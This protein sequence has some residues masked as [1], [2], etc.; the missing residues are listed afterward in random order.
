LYAR[1]NGALRRAHGNIGGASL[2]AVDADIRDLA[3]TLDNALARSPAPRP[4][5]LA[6]G[7]H[8]PAAVKAVGNLKVGDSFVDP[9][10]VSTSY[11][12][13]IAR[14][15]ASWLLGEQ[16]NG[17]KLD[18]SVPEGYPTL[19]IPSEF[20]K[21]RELLL[22]RGGK[23]TVT[24][25]EEASASGPKTI[26][27]ALSMPDA[28]PEATAI[29]DGFN[30]E[31]GPK[32]QFASEPR[33]I[34]QVPEAAEVGGSD[35]LNPRE[36]VFVLR[37]SQFIGKKLHVEPVDS[38]PSWSDE[39]TP[40]IEMRAVLGDPIPGTSRRSTFGYKFDSGADRFMSAI[41]S[42][43]PVAIQFYPATA[44]PKAE[45]VDADELLRKFG[46][47]DVTPVDAAE[48]P[49]HAFTP[50]ERAAG[51]T[52]GGRWYTDENGTNWFGKSYRGSSDRVEVEHL[53]NRIYREFGVSA[54]ETEVVEQAGKRTMMSRELPGKTSSPQALATANAGDGFVV[55]AWLAN[56]DAVGTGYDNMLLDADGVV[57]RIDN[58]GS[59]IYRAQG[60]RKDFAAP[61]RELE[62]MRNPS[63]PSGEVFGSLSEK[64]ID[65]QLVDFARKYE[66][67]R[68]TIDRMVDDS[69]LSAAAKKEVKQG[70]HERAEWLKAQAPKG[71]ALEP[72]ADLSAL[73]GK[74]MP[75]SIAAELSTPTAP[76]AEPDLRA[77]GGRPTQFAADAGP[78]AKTAAVT[79]DDD[80]MA[81]LSGTKSALDEGKSFKS[82][83]KPAEEKY[84]AEK[85]AK[86]EAAAEHFRGK[87]NAKNF[88]ASDMGAAEQAANP[89]RI[90]LEEA[91][92]NAVPNQSPTP[93]ASTGKKGTV[94]SYEGL[95]RILGEP[96]MDALATYE[97]KTKVS[98]LMPE[99]MQ[100]VA[101]DAAIERLL[102]KR[103]GKNVDMG[104]SLERAAKIIGDHE[105]A[106]AD[107]A[108][109]LGANAP[110]TAVDRASKLR[111]ASQRQ[112]DRMAAS[113][114]RAAD[115]LE[116]TAV[117]P[118]IRARVLADGLA[119]RPALPDTTIV[120][121][122]GKTPK[123]RAAFGGPDATVVEPDAEVNMALA[124]DHAQAQAR[125]AKK[126]AK[127][128]PGGGGVLGAAAD[129]GTALE[130]L[131]AMGVHTPMLSRIPLIGPVLG[132]VLKARAVL[133]IL[134]RKGGSVGRSTEALIA[135]RMSETQDRINGA[136]QALLSKAGR[137]ARKVSEVSAGPAVTLGY[138]LFPGGDAKKTKDLAA[139]YHARMD[140]I[141]RAQQ[142]GAIEHAIGDRYQTADA[143]LQSAIA[144]QVKRGIDFI[145]SKAPKPVLP[146][147]ML[148]GDG[149]WR[150][151]KAALEEW[152]RY[153]H[154]VSDPVSVL[155]DLAK[156]HF[157]REGAQTLQYVYPELFKLAQMMLIK[158]APQMQAKLP[159]ARQIA[160]SIMYRI[161]VHP[162]MQPQSLAYL[163]A[164]AA[165]AS[166]A[167][168]GA[169]GQPPPQGAPGLTGPIQLG[170]Q[171]MT[172]LD[173]RANR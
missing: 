162:S 88:A 89:K 32:K 8:D 20:P 168:P 117:D 127:A 173:M 6:R 56:W 82:I 124:R 39:S 43:R 102:K 97:A 133:G 131:G 19:A 36:H 55:D 104:P 109:L 46:P 107:V 147:G 130:L 111:T 83:S 152:G 40:A 52:R 146:P 49:R 44:R 171:A 33:P 92:R 41:A 48:Q 96:D 87:A 151:S 47:A 148:P 26:R 86:T 93:D 136:T 31:F 78:S 112:A 126:A 28:A 3:V 125:G 53:A 51:G 58:G 21:E 23:F 11:D 60:G 81:L 172:S 116:R 158:T 157:S 121:P 120:E 13:Q 95:S 166:G 119:S 22:G 18:I 70:L 137:G 106:S 73:A 75:E 114:A 24:G 34:T 164:P 150:P 30:I 143:E 69:G 149:K 163:A 159:Y 9:G 71:A 140:E 57:H 61:V 63:Q 76:V 65:R 160:I 155:E 64:D 161:P 138:S 142:P 67:L 85:A 154:A 12:D 118:G 84:V 90:D 79:T 115:D 108:D 98:S 59:L 167:Q 144:A 123:V 145:A 37:P 113:A 2:K 100:R 16:S 29:P 68:P 10:F 132:A 1:I 66:Q 156:G 105:Q 77:L 17:I 141:A 38:L 94:T 128:A 62:T 170:Q 101:D 74:A 42:D 110:R 4:M 135:Q 45:L 5:V 25:I 139:L 50:S 54:P 153:I 134:G 15:Y 129:A 14:D 35:G 72:A 7:I 122:R 91:L 165:G 103:T 80:L 99:D 27:L 169:P